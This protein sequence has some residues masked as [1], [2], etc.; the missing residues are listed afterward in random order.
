MNNT[1]PI[2]YFDWDGTL[3][4]SMDLCIAECREALLAMGL[5]DLPDDVIR[6][7][8]GVP[9]SDWYDTRTG[10]Y[11]EFIARSVQ[12]GLFMPMLV[13]MNKPAD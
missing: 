6:Q 11:V 8:N 7:C 13:E 9:F 4:D 12:G 2:I 10:D 1:R 5:P 3:A